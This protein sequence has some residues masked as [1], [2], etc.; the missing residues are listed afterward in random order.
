VTRRILMYS[1]VE[2]A[3]RGGVQAVYRRLGQSLRRRGLTVVQAWSRH[4]PHDDTTRAIPL[5]PPDPGPMLRRPR[6]LAG[7]LRAFV[8]LAVVLARVRPH[9][10]N[11]H[12]VTAEA[13]YLVLLKPLFRYRLVLSAHGSDVLRPKPW[14][15]PWIGRILRRADVVTAVSDLAATE[16]AAR[17]R[18]AHEQVVTIRNGIDIAFWS[19]GDGVPVAQRSPIVLSVG[20][21]H[22]VKGHDVLLQAFAR[23]VPRVPAARL[24]IVGDGGADA[25]LKV[26]ARTLGIDARVEFVAAEPPHAI[27]KRLAGARCFVLPSRSEGLPLALL[28]AMAAGTPAIAT[29]VGGVREVVDERSATLV[30]A[31]NVPALADALLHLLSADAQA[32][33]QVIHA[34]QRVAPCTSAAADAAYLRLLIDG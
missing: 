8:R 15:A 19:A 23:V 33:A 20:R 25:E 6:K 9:A 24:V 2:P 30:E 29:R 12:F 7:A 17:Y 4:D 3:D 1:P 13:W 18:V 21:L 10:V 11:W 14:N 27:R 22:P 16:L 32:A 28:E 34:R 31:G 26:L 5:P